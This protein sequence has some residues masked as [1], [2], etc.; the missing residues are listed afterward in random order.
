MSRR[1]EVIRGSKAGIRGNFD[2]KD[3]VFYRSTHARLAA[4]FDRTGRHIPGIL[5]SR[6]G[7]YC[8]R[9]RS[10]LLPFCKSDDGR[11]ATLDSAS[12]T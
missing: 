6:L 11:A 12:I 10:G 3:Q 4:T 9:P 2:L 7:S 1:A 8:A 5:R